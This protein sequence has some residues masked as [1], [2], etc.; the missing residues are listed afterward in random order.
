[1]LHPLSPFNM[2][3][4]ICILADLRAFAPADIQAVAATRDHA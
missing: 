3:K 4:P 2:V 1:V